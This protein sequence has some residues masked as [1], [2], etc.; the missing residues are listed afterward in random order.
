MDSHYGVRRDL[1][2]YRLSSFM[3]L[4]NRDGRIDALRGLAVLGVLLLHT[5]NAWYLGA[6]S[7]LAVESMPR[8]RDHWLGI[9]SIPTTFGF[10]GLN[11]FFVLSGLCIH[12][13]TLK[14][15]QRGELIHCLGQAI[16]VFPDDRLIALC[17]PRVGEQPAGVSFGEAV[18]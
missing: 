9:L 6:G 18:G 12:L 5:Q 1:G 15:G 13:W 7:D 16:L 11:L 4:P 17:A 14:R 3:E 10:L 2:D 8:L